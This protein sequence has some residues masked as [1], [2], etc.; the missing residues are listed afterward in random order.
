VVVEHQKTD[1]H[2]VRILPR[3][4]G[5]DPPVESISAGLS[6]SP[7]LAS[8]VEGV[9]TLIAPREALLPATVRRA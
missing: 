5:D 4:P 7:D 8:T 1:G 3:D 2:R 9:D 6:H